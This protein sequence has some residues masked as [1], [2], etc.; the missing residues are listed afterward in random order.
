APPSPIE[1]YLAQQNLKKEC[2]KNRKQQRMTA[3]KEVHPPPPK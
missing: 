1:K 2:R 3:E